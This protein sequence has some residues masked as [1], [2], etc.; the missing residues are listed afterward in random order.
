MYMFRTTIFVELFKNMFSQQVRLIKFSLE[1]YNIQLGLKYF[2]ILLQGDLQFS[3]VFFYLYVVAKESKAP[4][5]DVCP[6][7]P[8][9]FVA[10]F[11]LKKLFIQCG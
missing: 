9:N 2:F 10:L 11:S 5:D 4:F 7:H 8:F 3:F 1:N 6:S